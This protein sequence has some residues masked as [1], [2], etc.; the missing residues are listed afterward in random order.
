MW[1]VPTLSLSH[2]KLPQD[3]SF[4]FVTGERDKGLEGMAARLLRAQAQQLGWAQAVQAVHQDGAVFKAGQR[5]DQARAVVADRKR[6]LRRRNTVL[7]H[8]PNLKASG[9][10]TGAC[11]QTHC[12]SNTVLQQ[13]TGNNYILLKSVN[14]DDES[15]YTTKNVLLKITWPTTQRGVLLE[16]NNQRP[17]L[18]MSCFI[19]WCIY[20]ILIN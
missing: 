18:L 8:H 2:L 15:L 16:E 20:I 5:L 1:R 9:W 4:A 12:S 3:L 14:A 17:L 19:P 10:K 7:S 6:A 11:L 13:N